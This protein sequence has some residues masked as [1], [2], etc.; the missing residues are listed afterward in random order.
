MLQTKGALLSNVSQSHVV[1]TSA[2]IVMT[3][4]AV[5]GWTT[6]NAQTP[7][8]RVGSSGDR[9]CLRLR[10]TDSLRDWNR[11]RIGGH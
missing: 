2:A 7:V 11:T 6:D 3:A 5:I 4:I 9:C 8:L 1:T 10:Y